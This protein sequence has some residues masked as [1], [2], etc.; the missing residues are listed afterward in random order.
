MMRFLFLILIP[1]F[2]AAGSSSDLSIQQLRARSAPRAERGRFSAS[3]GTNILHGHPQYESDAA[4]ELEGIRD[5]GNARGS[6]GDHPQL[7]AIGYIS[8][9]YSIHDMTRK[10][11]CKRI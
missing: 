6:S 4:R 8:N 10:Q 3:G 9:L 7:E 1:P 2:K 11:S 5:R